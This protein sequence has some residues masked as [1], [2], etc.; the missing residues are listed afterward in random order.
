MKKETIIK[1]IVSTILFITIILLEIFGLAFFKNY[2]ILFCS[3]NQS[4]D[5]KKS[6]LK[7]QGHYLTQEHIP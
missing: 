6:S 5:I 4:I 2:K 3:S 7:L 1:I